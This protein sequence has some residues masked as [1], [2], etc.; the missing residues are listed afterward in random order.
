LIIILNV[1]IFVLE[2][3]GGDRFVL[4]YSVIPAEIVAGR[5][6]VNLL[7][8][9]FMHAGWMHIVGNMVFLWVFGPPIEASMG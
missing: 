5:S 3:L 2:L 6:L 7:T 4:T 1:L 9:M 8:A